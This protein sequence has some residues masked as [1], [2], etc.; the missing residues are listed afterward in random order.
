[1]PPIRNTPEGGKGAGRRERGCG[2]GGRHLDFWIWGDFLVVVYNVVVDVVVA[3]IF[4]NLL[5]SFE[6]FGFLGGT[7]QCGCYPVEKHLRIPR[8][9]CNFFVFLK[10]P[11]QLVGWYNSYVGVAIL[12]EIVRK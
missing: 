3:C 8:L 4:E 9:L 12:A 11:L 1:M 2:R 5:I 6:S 10:L 7:V